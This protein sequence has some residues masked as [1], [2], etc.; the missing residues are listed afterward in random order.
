MTTPIVL[1][2][3]FLL[4]QIVAT[5]HA[6]ASLDNFDVQLALQRH[7]QGDWGEVGKEDRAANEQALLNGARLLSIY[8]S[9]KGV[10]FY[11]ITEWDRSLTTILLP[12][13]Y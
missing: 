8:R 7:I 4:G 1:K 9:S 3:K 5:A 12:S 13:D 6:M 10:K 2:A 11:V